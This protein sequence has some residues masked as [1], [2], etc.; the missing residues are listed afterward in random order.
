MAETIYYYATPPGHKGLLILEANKMK[1]VRPSVCHLKA[2]F[3]EMGNE[4]FCSFCLDLFSPFQ[5]N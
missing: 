5:L 3:A 2:T 4:I 1:N